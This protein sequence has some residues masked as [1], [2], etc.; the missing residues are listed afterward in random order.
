MSPSYR[1]ATEEDLSRIRRWKLPSGGY[2]QVEL[3]GTRYLLAPAQNYGLHVGLLNWEAA[4]VLARRALKHLR[5][6]DRE[7]SEKL[8]IT[9][10]VFDAYIDALTKLSLLDS[11]LENELAFADRIE[12]IRS[13]LSGNE[14]LIN[15]AALL[16]LE[17]EAFQ[18]EFQKKKEEAH[19]AMLSEQRRLVERELKEQGDVL[20]SLR[21]DL[22]NKAQ[23][24][25]HLNEEIKRKEAELRD[26][27]ESFERELITRLR[28]LANQPEKLFAE[29]A[30]VRAAL[31]P[32]QIS[33]VQRR[34]RQES[35]RLSKVR[36]LALPE[37]EDHED[38][39]GAVGIRLMEAGISPFIGRFLHTAFLAGFV[40]VVFG[41]AA[42]EIL[43]IYATVATADRFHWI[44]IGGTVYEPSDL[45]AR[46]DPSSR[47]LIPHPGGLLD[48]LVQAKESQD[49]H[50]VILEGF[51][52]APV[53]SYL[54]PLLYSLEDVY[55]GQNPRKIPLVSSGLLAP[56]D[57]Y[58]RAES[59]SW[60]PNVLLALVP[61][62]G[63][64][65]LPTTDLVWRY[66]VPIDSD[67]E[68]PLGI[69]LNP[70]TTS[71]SETAGKLVT[72]IS[73]KKWQEWKQ[74]AR[75]VWL[76]K[77]PDILRDSIGSPQLART[78]RQ[79][80]LRLHAVATLS[81]FSDE[82]AKEFALKMGLL[83]SLAATETRDTS[84]LAELGLSEDEQTRKILEAMR[85]LKE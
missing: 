16:F 31:M 5:K 63:G 37:L 65:T 20:R 78:D 33:D 68:P 51:N 4:E 70:Y 13:V 55:I 64:S 69:D 34:R 18:I 61:V 6:R 32:E 28:N 79:K 35:N 50:L 25:Q 60:Q 29:A 74:E 7:A 82:K 39:L 42:Q 45:L 17:T 3:D 52:R 49:M 76:K 10:K 9:K 73:A 53:E 66:A 59:V 38:I 2:A 8:E 58:V 56:D 19:E 44:P 72:Q 71:G 54:L 62:L 36:E 47:I 80:V 15:E 30:I 24:L 41:T 11:D 43:S 12:E 26:R 67:A 22:S 1:L 77:I 23:E 46:F 83:P 85:S 84:S 57:P 48:V 81:G 40:P 21:E 14:D 27:E 75:L